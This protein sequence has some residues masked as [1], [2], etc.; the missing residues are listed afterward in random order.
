MTS[1]RV[2]RLLPLAAA[3]IWLAACGGGDSAADAEPAATTVSSVTLDLAPYSAEEQQRVN[4]LQAQAGN[5][6]PRY[7]VT[8]NPAAVAEAMPRSR[9]IL[10]TGHLAASRQQ[11]AVQQVAQRLLAGRG[12]RVLGHYSQ[13]L[14]GFAATVPEAQAERFVAELADHPAV[15]AIERDRPIQATAL[16]QAAAADGRWGLDRIDQARLPLDGWFTNTRDGS[17]V[18][19]YVV[20]SGISAHGEFGARL[21]AGHDAIGDGTGTADCTGHGSH[22]AGIAAGAS[23]GVAPGAQLVPVRVIGCGGSGWGSSLIQG[24]DWIATHGVRPGVVNLSLGSSASAATDQAVARL[25]SAGF[26]VVVS[27]GND[28]ADACKYSPARAASALTVGATDVRDTRAVFSNFGSCLDL[29]A[30][31]T[32]IASAA[33]ADAAALVTKQGTSMATPFVTGAAALVLQ[34]RPK[35]TAA[36][37][38]TQLTTQATASA[39]KSSGAGSKNKLLFVGPARQVVFPTPWDVHVES[40]GVAT[41]KSGRSAWVTTVTIAVHQEE[42]QPLKGVKV[43]ARFSNSNA[44]RSCVTAA[45]GTCALSSSTLRLDLAAVTLAVSDLSGTALTYRPADNVLSAVTATV[46]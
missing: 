21:L 43:S 7:I 8:L 3:A 34:E 28:N 4:A 20:D 36:Q 9:A 15:L 5:S 32:N 13:A 22:V 14:Q 1:P 24:L 45:N 18:T 10:S 27:A 39:V 17:G 2:T 31:G 38:G 25:T 26:T 11:V 46:P 33:H 40:L 6:E 44:L 16:R 41:R 19:I 35:L 37:V 29:F 23:V 30:P 42:G 12:A